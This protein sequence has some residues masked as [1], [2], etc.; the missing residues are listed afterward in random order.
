MFRVV[1]PAA[2]AAV[3]A[4]NAARRN[5]DILREESEEEEEENDD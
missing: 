1:N 3:A 2:Y 5:L 4:V